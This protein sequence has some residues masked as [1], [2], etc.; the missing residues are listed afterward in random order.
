MARNYIVVV[1]CSRIFQGKSRVLAKNC[2][3]QFSSLDFLNLNPKVHS[4]IYFAKKYMKNFKLLFLFLVIL[5]VS[6][7]ASPKGGRGGEGGRSGG[8]NR[9]YY[10]DGFDVLSWLSIIPPFLSCLIICIMILVCFKNCC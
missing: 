1:V 2:K 10:G 6:T 3:H 5:F 4:T 9:G 8:R 7:E